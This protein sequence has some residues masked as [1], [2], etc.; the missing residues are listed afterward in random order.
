M[1]TFIT[2]KNDLN[3]I[4][5]ANYYAFDTK[6]VKNGIS[7]HQ[8]AII[9]PK[10][11]YKPN[12]TEGL[13]NYVG[14]PETN[15]GQI[16]EIQQRPYKEV[17][18]RNIIQKGDTLFAR[19][20]PSIFNKKYIFAD[21]LNEGEKAFTSTEFY[22]VEAND[23]SDSK[24]IFYSMFFDIVFNQVKGKTTGS[25]GR[26]RLDRE[27]F[28]SL[29]IP[30]PE[31]PV[32]EKIVN[33][34][35][36]AYQ[37]KQVL[38]QEAERLA[39][40]NYKLLLEKLSLNFVL[41]KQQKA[42]VV[43][44][45]D[46]VENR[47]DPMFYSNVKNYIIQTISNSKNTVKPL[48]ELIVDS[49]AGYWGNDETKKKENEIEINV[50]RNTNFDNKIN[51]NLEDVAIRYVEPSKIESRKLNRGDLLIEKSGGSPAQPVGRVCLWDKDI[52]EDYIFSNFLQKITI[53]TEQCLP[54][55]IFVYL[56]ALYNIGLMEYFQN[57]TTGIKNL[58]WEEFI[59]SPIVLPELSVQRELAE[60]VLERNNEIIRLE[61]KADKTLAQAKAQVEEI[62][63][64]ET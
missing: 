50:V 61:E 43:S 8:I 56:R 52:A 48:S 24:Y 14:L 29:T 22:V 2:A 53:D 36:S 28:E 20:E 64:G 58:I 38:E 35:D 10:R 6:R 5:S 57:Q 33:I 23:T 46:V 1:K 18:G 19:I 17:K 49:S 31:K 42:F 4:L 55:Y 16:V 13:V 27:I 47:I 30:Y 62:I 37:K 60:F 59:G 41:P 34:L 44:I 26:R 25:T 51:L 11:N 12:S 3:G 15:D 39:K 45:D 9:N 63:L 40:N 54:E 21:R 32:R 7:L